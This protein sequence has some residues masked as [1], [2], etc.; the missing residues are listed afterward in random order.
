MEKSQFVGYGQ[1]NL[2]GRDVRMDQNAQAPD[3]SD[4]LSLSVDGDGVEPLFRQLYNE[5]RRV[6]LGGRGPWQPAAGDTQPGCQ[7]GGLSHFGGR[8]L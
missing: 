8:R 4:L 1:T 6:I 2:S 3:W 7:A 5:L